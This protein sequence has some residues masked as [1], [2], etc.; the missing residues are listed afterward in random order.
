MPF[1]EEQMHDIDNRVP[2]L[3]RQAVG[4]AIARA[5]ALGL[6][7][8]VRIDDDLVEVW[9]DGRRRVVKQ[10]R[11]KVRIERGKRIKPR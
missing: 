6:S 11:P 7:V 5:R 9:P 8:T 10:L 2:E 3:A 4:E 1:D